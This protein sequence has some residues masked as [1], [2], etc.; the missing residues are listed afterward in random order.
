MFL[1]TMQYIPVRFHVAFLNLKQAEIKH[2][3][4]QIAFFSH[5]YTSIVVLIAGIFQFSKTI[6][7]NYSLLHRCAGLFY[8]FLILCVAA[9]SGFIMAINANGGFFSKVSF[10]IQAILWFFFTY[11]AYVYIKDKN[12]K[13][14]QNF[15]LRSYALTLS[16]ISL[17]LFKWVI[18]TLFEL[19]PMDTYK[20]VSWLGWLFNI[21]VVE[22]YLYQSNYKK[23]EVSK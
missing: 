22:C 7:N 8:V 19:P 16:A 20:I 1:I 18:V 14:H 10:S 4:Y 21:I 11:K 6:K 2:G 23:R 3:Y 13:A 9:P 5:V 12:I 17:R 15:M